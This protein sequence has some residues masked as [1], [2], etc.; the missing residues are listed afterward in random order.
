M[1]RSPCRLSTGPGGDSRDVCDV[2][3]VHCTAPLSLT[4]GQVDDAP[5]CGN[6]E[7]FL[8]DLLRGAKGILAIEL[9]HSHAGQP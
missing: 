3:D 8:H 4:H 6:A 9:H 1:T 2:C 5:C 7:G